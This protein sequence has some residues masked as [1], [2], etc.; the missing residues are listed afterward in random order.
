MLGCAL[1]PGVAA[2]ILTLFGLAQIYSFSVTLPRTTLNPYYN[3][4]LHVRFTGRPKSLGEKVERD[5]RSLEG[6]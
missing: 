4:R 6:T 5:S 2:T 3:F 1:A